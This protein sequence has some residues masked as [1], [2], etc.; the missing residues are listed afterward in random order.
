MAPTYKLIY[1]NLRGRAEL[2]RYMFAVGGQEYEDFRFDRADWPEL[3]LKMP[4][5]QCPVLE[6]TEDGK[7]IQLAQSLAIARYLARKF[8]LY[9]KNETEMAEIDM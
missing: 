5:G 8:N 6:I 9:G 2:H 7:T 3:K 1:Y 4:F